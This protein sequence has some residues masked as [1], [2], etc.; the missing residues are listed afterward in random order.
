[1]KIRE[2]KQ[3]ILFFLAYTKGCIQELNMSEQDASKEAIRIIE[4]EKEFLIE[5][6]PFDVCKYKREVEKQYPALDDGGIKFKIE[7]KYK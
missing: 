5:P 1:M 2:L 6:Y 4:K 7:Y 3:D